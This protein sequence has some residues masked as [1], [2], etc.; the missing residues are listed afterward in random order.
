MAGRPASRG[1]FVRGL[2]ADAFRIVE[3]GTPQDVSFFM[4]QDA[5]ATIGLLIDASG[6]M[7]ESRD[8]MIAG[9]TTFAETS[10]PDD[11]FLPLV[12]NETLTPALPSGFTGD[13]LEL[14]DA[15]TGSLQ[16]FGRTAFHDALVDALDL[17]SRGRHER[18]AL[19]VL[20]D[21]GDNESRLDFEDALD[22]VMA[23]NVVIYTIALVDPLAFDQ[24]PRALRR[25]AE[26]TGGLAFRPD[27]MAGV[28]TALRTIARDIRSS[29]TLA[30]VPAEPDGDGR[31][32]RVRV[33]ARSPEH[34]DLKVRTRTGYVAADA[35]AR[36]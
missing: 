30:Y 12:F 35:S 26:A 31:F 23:S 32:R 18:M 15:L 34:R 20:S 5:P 13:P 10:H 28:A 33:T 16:T 8:R 14:R 19:V 9:I 4:E 29:Y 11:E 7:I 22:R 17:L 21:G 25:L 36:D 1:G 27:D 2:P 3:D 24:N 6:S